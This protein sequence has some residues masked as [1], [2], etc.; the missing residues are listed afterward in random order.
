MLTDSGRTEAESR[1]RVMTD[2]LYS[3]FDEEN[4][5]EWKDYLDN[6]LKNR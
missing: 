4:A 5:P 1:D 2:F 6:Y 3:L